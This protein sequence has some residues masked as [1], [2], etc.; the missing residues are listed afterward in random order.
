M[1]GILG[2]RRIHR[3]VG[4]ERNN[5]ADA[6]GFGA[7]QLS[8]LSNRIPACL[9]ILISTNTT[10]DVIYPFQFQRAPEMR[11]KNKVYYFSLLVYVKMKQ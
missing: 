11:Y 4:E 2:L 5:G 10:T 9:E 7:A 1:R 3:Q 8:L 6:L